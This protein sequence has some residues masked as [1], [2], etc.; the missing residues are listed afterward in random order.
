MDSPTPKW[1]PIGVDPRPFVWGRSSRVASRLSLLA[2]RARLGFE[3]WPGSGAAAEHARGPSRVAPKPN[4]FEQLG[5][6]QN[7][8]TRGPQALVIV[9]IWGAYF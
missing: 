3:T 6:G 7:S 9:S 1:D 5:R 2:P 4:R 8:T